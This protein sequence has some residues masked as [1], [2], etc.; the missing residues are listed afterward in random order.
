MASVL[1]KT[2]RPCVLLVFAWLKVR[3]LGKINQTEKSCKAQEERVSR[4]ELGHALH[5]R[6]EN[7]C[8][9]R[10]REGTKP[11]LI[12]YGQRWRGKLYAWQ[13]L[14]Q[15]VRKIT[16]KSLLSVL[17]WNKGAENKREF[18]TRKSKILLNFERLFHSV[19][20]EFNK[21]SLSSIKFE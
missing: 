16:A 1:W 19:F 6:S 17:R 20:L 11:G 21:V 10:R 7:L 13:W 18:F 2:D 4:V 8:Q 14:G 5:G 12:G 3:E 9:R 15:W